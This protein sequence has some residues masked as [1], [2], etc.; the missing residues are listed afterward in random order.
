MSCAVDGVVEPG[1]IYPPVTPFIV[2]DAGQDP[3]G[4]TLGD[5]QTGQMWGPA[6][7][8]QLL[9][10]GEQIHVVDVNEMGVVVMYGIGDS[11]HLDVGCQRKEEGMSHLGVAAHNG[12][13]KQL[14][15][16]VKDRARIDWLLLGLRQKTLVDH[17]NRCGG[18]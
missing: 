13:P 2:F 8:D 18:R 5:A 17:R 1:S 6:E 4:R 10:V 7:F 9:M 11:F 15:V 3:F 16:S 14:H 12:I